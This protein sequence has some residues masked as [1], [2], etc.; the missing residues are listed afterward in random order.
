MEELVSGMWVEKYRPK[1]LDEL[2]LPEKYKKEFAMIIG[3]GNLPNLLLSGPPGGG[4]TTLARVICSKYGLLQNPNDNLLMVNGSAKKSRGIGFVDDVIEPFLRHPPSKDNYRVVF[5]DESDKLTNDGYDSL[6]AIIEKYHVAYG[7]FIFTCN[8]VSKIPDAIQSRFT[9]YAFSQIPKDYLMDYAKRILN[10]EEIKFEEKTV[11]LILNNLYPDVRKII[12]TLQRNSLHG[13]LDV[14]EES[15]T[16]NEKRIIALILQIISCLEKAEDSKIGGIV[17][18][19]IEVLS[20]QELEYRNIYTDLFFM[21]KI[22]TPA[23]II[24]NRYSNSHQNCLVSSMHFM[25]MVFE[26]IKA[27]QSYRKAVTGK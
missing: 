2:V 22:P 17:N 9:H 1:T 15:I 16:T 5:V 23:K 4:K 21:D 3:K 19:I 27:L 20:K 26:I 14:T 8:Y 7:R 10:S 18:S 6:R 12:N 24:I 13:K 11:S 25:A